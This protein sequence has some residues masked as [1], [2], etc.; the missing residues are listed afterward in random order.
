MPTVLRAAGLRF[1]F[2]SADGHEPPHIHIEGTGRK[3]KVWLQEVRVAKNG[4]FSEI[5]LSR[6]LEIVS[7]NRAKLLEAW[8]DFFA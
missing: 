5:E 6:I 7:K 8:N 2:Y 1:H 3:A 4:G